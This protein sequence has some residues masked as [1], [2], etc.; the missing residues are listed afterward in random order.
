MNSFATRFIP[1]WRLV[2]TQTSGGAIVFVDDLRRMMLDLQVYR[3]VAVAAESG[4]DPSRERTHPCFE[5][6]IFLERRT[7]GAA[8]CTKTKRPMYSGC[9]SS[10]RSTA[11]K[12]SI[13]PL[14]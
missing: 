14:V 2:T 8:I 1:S 5:M 10:K 3:L 4:V 7:R 9:C 6:L 12:R 11:R 13:M